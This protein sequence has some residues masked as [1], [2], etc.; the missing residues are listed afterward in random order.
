MTVN[1]VMWI[2]KVWADSAVAPHDAPHQRRLRRPGRAAAVL[3]RDLLVAADRP[4]Q[5][6]D[7]LVGCG[8]PAPPTGGHS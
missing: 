6:R 2:T 8:C 7:G 5:R 3:I 4:K 1:R